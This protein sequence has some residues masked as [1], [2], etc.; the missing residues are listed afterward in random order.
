MN[1]EILYWS[2]H[3]CR[4][5]RILLLR[6]QRKYFKKAKQ[7]G[8]SKSEIFIYPAFLGRKTF[9]LFMMMNRNPPPLKSIQTKKA[10]NSIQMKNSPIKS[11]NTGICSGIARWTNRNVSLIL[12]KISFC[13]EHFHIDLNMKS[14]R[15]YSLQAFNE[16]KNDL[17]NQ[18][19]ENPNFQKEFKD[20]ILKRSSTVV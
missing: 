15:R 3:R 13:F 6:K 19:L 17:L 10:M 20:E 14:Q 16:C 5:S 12:M 9:L 7:L 8:N 1:A 2:K 18:V 11:N 4:R